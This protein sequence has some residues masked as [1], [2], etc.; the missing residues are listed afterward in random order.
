MSARDKLLTAVRTSLGRDTALSAQ[1]I[2]TLE[3][4]QPTPVQLNLGSELVARFAAKLELAGGSVERLEGFDQ[5]GGAISNYL[6]THQ[7][8]NEV[9][10]S[11]DQVIANIDWPT[12][13]TTTSGAATGKELVSVTSALAGVAETGTLVLVSGEKTPTTL[14]FLPDDHI[15]VLAESQVIAQLEDAWAKLRGSGDMPRTVNLISAPSK[16]GDVELT[17]VQGAHGPRRLHVVLYKD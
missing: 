17:L 6:K 15:V 9:L 2:A 13:L 11:T 10:I 1:A 4:R 14:N 8:P 16:T 7:L 5:V 12:L 3:K